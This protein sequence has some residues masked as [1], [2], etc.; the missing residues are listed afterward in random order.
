VT[1][2][3]KVGASDR[4]VEAPQPNRREVA[5]HLLA[6]EQEIVLD[7]LRCRSELRAQIRTLCRDPNRTTVDVTRANHQAALGEEQSRAEADLVGTE[8]RG[9]D[10]VAA[11]LD[12]AIHAQA[13]ASAQAVG[14]ERALCVH[15]TELPGYACVLDRGERTRAGAAVGPGDV[16]DIRERLDDACRNEPDAGLRDELDRHVSVGVDLLEVEDQL[17]EVLDGIDVVVRRR[18]DERNARLCVAQTCDLGGHLVTGQLAALAGLGALRD[19]DLELGGERRVLGRDA[20]P[21]RSDLLDA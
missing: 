15:E 6:D 5:A 2:L 17:C 12:P 3:Q 19:L 14:D 20:E 13:H 11:G 1:S 9:D 18:G 16:D 21:A 4:L 7:H 8:E 10:D